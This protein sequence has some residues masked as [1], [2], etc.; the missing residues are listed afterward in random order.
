MSLETENMSIPPKRIL[1]VDD[2][3]DIRLIISHNLRKEGYDVLN[4]ESAES[5]L[6]R[7]DLGSMDLFILDVMMEGM[8]GFEMAAELKRRPET[9][10][11]P[12]IFITAKDSED[13]KVEGFEAGADDYISKPFSVREMCSRVKAVL[14]RAGQNGKPASRTGIEIDDERKTVIVDSS[15][16]Q[17]SH[18]E[19]EILRLLFTHPGKVFSRAEMLS[20]VW[21]D[22]VIVTD[23]SVDVAITRLRKKISPYGTH[24]VSRHGFG[25]LWDQEA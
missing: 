9:A 22:D 15:H 11:A 8:S 3:E 12:V 13:D 18:N 5:A 21:S 10:K 25:Y 17:L 4:C 23:R 24:I 19:F 2:E 14:R 1:V 7:D 16:I 6:S 20:H